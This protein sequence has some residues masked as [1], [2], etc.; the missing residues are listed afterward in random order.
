[1]QDQTLKR[2][3]LR[4]GG[5]NAVAEALK[6]TP[7]A[8]YFWLNGTRKPSERLLS[9]LGLKRVERFVRERELVNQ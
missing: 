6:V 2:E 5:V 7:C 1:M 8:V 9:Y 4:K 3:V